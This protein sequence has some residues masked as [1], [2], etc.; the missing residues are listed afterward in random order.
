MTNNGNSLNEKVF[1]F[2]KNNLSSSESDKKNDL[3]QFGLS[4]N[5]TDIAEKTN[6]KRGRDFPKK[7]ENEQ[8]GSRL[9]T[10]GLGGNSN[11][12]IGK[13]SKLN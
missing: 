10:F 3:E 4:S 12:N 8:G 11:K 5:F 9:L 6:D 7:L 13:K 2:G 1:S